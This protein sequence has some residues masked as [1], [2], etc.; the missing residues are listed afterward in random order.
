MHCASCGTRLVEAA[1]YCHVCGTKIGGVQ[2]QVASSFAPVYEICTTTFIMTKDRG[3]GPWN[4]KA[5]WQWIAVANGPKGKY[6][7]A[8][9]QEF[10]AR[11]LQESNGR[12]G[13]SHHAEEAKDALDELVAALLSSG[14][15]PVVND[16]YRPQFRRRVN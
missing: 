6:N 7:A 12:A 3:F 16:G 15:E 1:N 4:D 2:T 10:K 5:T 13:P 8:V 11:Y 9:S 14:W